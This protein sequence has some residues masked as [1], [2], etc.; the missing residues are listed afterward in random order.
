MVT[1]NWVSQTYGKAKANNRWFKQVVKDCI[2]QLRKGI[3]TYCFSYEQLMYIKEKTP[4]IKIFVNY[5]KDDGIYYI[6]YKGV[7]R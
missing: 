4:N 3:N 2:K 1:Q 5:K 7:I 6:D